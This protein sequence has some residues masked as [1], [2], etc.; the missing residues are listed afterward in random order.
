MASGY[1]IAV[2]PY[3]LAGTHI[4]DFVA[5]S[6][7][8]DRTECKH[9]LRELLY[10]SA[11]NQMA[12]IRARISDGEF[13]VVG[14]PLQPGRECYIEREADSH[15]YWQ[16]KDNDFCH[17]LGPRQ[18]GKS[19]LMARVAS[20]LRD[21]QELVA[22]VDLSQ[23]GVRDKS[24]D[25]G[26]WYY[27]IAYRIVRELRLKVDLQSW[28]QART[29][30]PVLQRLS[31]FFW[32]IVL[33]NT[34]A[35]VTI[36]IDEIENT[37]LLSEAGDFF[38]S[39][40]ACHTARATEPDYNRLR[41]VLLGVATPDMLAPDAGHAPFNI[42]K[43]IDLKDF[44]FEQVLLLARGMGLDPATAEQALKRVL[45]W[46]GGQPY[47]TQK[48]C[49][50]VARTGINDD[51]AASV[52]T[53]VRDRFLSRNRV[54]DE[55]NLSLINSRL[56]SD[57]KATA[58]ILTLLGK[59]GKG[60][61]VPLDRNS[62]WQ[63]QLRLSGVVVA[64]KKGDLAFRNRIYRQVFT[65]RWVNKSL[66]FDWKGF[67]TAVSVGLLIFAVPIWYTHLLP[68]PYI[69]TLSAVTED[70]QLALDAYEDL[71]SIPGYRSTA[72]RL[73][74][75][76]LRRRSQRA[77]TH[78]AATEA[79][80]ALLQLPGYSAMADELMSQF[81]ERQSVLLESRENRDAALMYRLKAL[82]VSS[83]QRRRDVTRLIGFDY[84]NLL[85][86]VRTD[87]PMGS[88]AVSADGQELTIV[89]HGNR[90]SRWLTA[91]GESLGKV[92]ML[93]QA[94]EYTRLERRVEADL[95]GAVRGIEMTVRVRHEQP[96]D[97]WVELRSPQGNAVVIDLLDGG[98]PGDVDY[99][100]DSTSQPDLMAFNAQPVRGTWT[101]SVSD[102]QRDNAGLLE[103]WSLKFAGNRSRPVT[104]HPDT[105]VEIPEPITT[106]QVDVVLSPH[107]RLVAARSNNLEQG[108]NVIVWDTGSGDIIEQTHVSPGWTIR[109]FNGA[110]NLLILI[111][112]D[113][114][115]KIRVW[116]FGQSAVDL[117]MK[118]GRVADGAAVLASG[119][120]F[121]A[122][123]FVDE[124]GERGFEVW[125][126]AQQTRI[127]TL[128]YLSE[129]SAL[130][131]S[132]E[133]DYL[134][135]ANRE[136]VVQL[137]YIP[138]RGLI[139]AF[140]HE[141]AVQ[142]LRFDPESQWLI[143]VDAELS[144][145][146][147]PVDS[148]DTDLILAREI[149]AADDFDFAGPIDA[150]L[151]RLSENAYELISLPDG[152]ATAPP[153][154]HAKSTGQL[155]PA[156]ADDRSDMSRFSASGGVI[157]TATD[158][159]VARIWTTGG[160][161]LEQPRFGVMEEFS[162]AS[163]NPDGTILALGR[164]DGSLKIWR[165]AGADPDTITA[166]APSP[167]GMDPALT[168]VTISTDNRWVSAASRSGELWLLDLQTGESM[169]PRVWQDRGI[170]SSLAFS[171]DSTLL[172][173]AGNRGARIWNP[174]NSELLHQLGSDDPVVDI[175]FSSDNELIAT[176]SDNGELNL[177]NTSDGQMRSNLSI[178][179]AITAA[180]FSPDN[181]FIA[182]G[183]R[184]GSVSIWDLL[185]LNRHGESISINGT[186]L[187]LRFSPDSTA[188]IVQSGEWMHL[189]AVRNN[190]LNI[191][192]SRM[193]PGP[194]YKNAFR[195]V[196]DD[197]TRIEYLRAAYADSA[198]LATMR[199]DTVAADPIAGTPAE[200]LEMWQKKLS[201]RFGDDGQIIADTKIWPE[202]G[203]NPA[204]VDP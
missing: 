29:G 109:S 171:A 168:I 61:S 154:R 98:K 86:T 192:A 48:L 172:A 128:P 4:E 99:V 202:I 84:P 163:M 67:A 126:L 90:I 74:A 190:G 117:V 44:S 178:G 58:R 59:V 8:P 157:V 22:I 73:F 119:A 100:F 170:A 85:A 194:V 150:V 149:Y 105:P 107:G 81:W 120:G 97:L 14:G 1:C 33:A 94:D 56:T 164:D 35:S 182:V 18:Y 179:E 17:V 68:R 161:A 127:A 155:P 7:Q 180:T 203:T 5:G 20:R 113:I 174:V 11:M 72:E 197:A 45:F 141:L 96:D 80:R 108:G 175:V 118:K 50:A 103:G 64:N 16:L 191:S 10:F 82:A 132:D 142:H 28:W 188:L 15:L 76:V 93:V 13:F 185:T 83:D 116:Q 25:L 133:G 89:Q 77:D 92:P 87:A 26:R 198:Q 91:T 160:S 187:G 139:S 111:S 200:L 143:S 158:R 195:I 177:W 70:Y 41:F 165:S 27:G 43:S 106:E 57:N 151:W 162:T 65:A 32:E 112:A 36:F 140:V 159:R 134:A 12:K 129:Y 51:I 167:S 52:D 125:D 19:S 169:L 121:A 37:L 23:I 166:P 34:T 146:V 30:L 39:L 130:A 101:L 110:E 3:C 135:I 144:G 176:C 21:D 75:S 55:P 137:Y 115:E 123:P 42:S 46:T 181:R 104:D 79:N 78:A 196:E 69:E 186:V 53:L 138:D 131:L 156:A 66:P 2:F 24:D 173:S 60:Q 63:N 136:N 40:R 31:E 183:T 189:F 122:L 38:A 204:A 184:N 62:R 9:I 71:R 124:R 54:H 148:V 47:M 88:L 95:D 6:R 49:R 145:R 152:H 102:R 147:W 193:M 114:P 199:F 153:Y 201:L